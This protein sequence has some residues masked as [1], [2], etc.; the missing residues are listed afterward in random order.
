[1]AYFLDNLRNNFDFLLR[2]PL[3]RKNYCE[4]PED[5][6]DVFENREE[7]KFYNALKEKYGSDLE[8]NTTQRIFLENIYFLNVFDKCLTKIPKE[9][10]SVLDVGSKNWSYV[11]S[12]YCFFKSFSGE[13]ALNGIELDAY[14]L[15]SRFFTRYEIA[16]FYTRDLP[17]A[18]YI[19]GDFLE[20]KGKYNYI[21]WILPFI[22]E[23]PLV[24]WG[25]PLRYFKPERMLEHAYSLLN[26]NGELLIINQGEEEYT[27][28][29]ELYKKLNLKPVL[30]GETQDNMSLFRNKR[31]ASKIVK[32]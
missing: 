32:Q 12:E 15:S 1:M 21:I 28:Q 26:T 25:L 19:A 16:K 23:Y 17:D 10:L 13:F 14:R 20:H 31:F 5:L 8:N 3:S 29:Q 6:S 2:N 18:H 4:K 24:K 22:T 30:Y 9:D 7:E 27:I 11:K